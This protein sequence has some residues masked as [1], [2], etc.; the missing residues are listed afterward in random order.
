VSGSS[1]LL[2]VAATTLAAAIVTLCGFQITA[3]R[4]DRKR[5][6]RPRTLEGPVPGRQSLSSIGLNT[7]T[8]RS[9]PS[10]SGHQGQRPTTPARIPKDNTPKPG[11]PTSDTS[12]LPPSTKETKLNSLQT[13]RARSAALH[14]DSQPGKPANPKSLMPA[15]APSTQ[16]PGTRAIP[17]RE[18][19]SAAPHATSSS[20]QQEKVDRTPPNAGLAGDSTGLATIQKTPTSKRAKRANAQTE[21]IETAHP[22]SD[23]APADVL[24]DLG[25]LELL[26]TLQSSM[27]GGSP[28]QEDGML[29]IFA[30]LS[31]AEVGLHDLTD[32]LNDIDGGGLPSAAQKTP[33]KSRR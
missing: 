2:Y 28:N 12:Q 6:R 11:L 8:G 19:G 24:A 14:T 29:D 4:M 20:E 18:Q 30:G 13:I 32:D 22:G 3:T 27:V 33:Q 26:D 16:R 9:T 1:V 10:S 15:Y 25:G 7:Q 23:Q 5:S 21:P 17:V 31:E